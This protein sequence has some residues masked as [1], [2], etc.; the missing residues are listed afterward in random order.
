MDRNP[1]GPTLVVLF[2]LF[3]MVGNG[4]EASLFAKI[5]KLAGGVG[6]I[7]KISPSPSPNSG[8]DSGPSRV[9][10]VNDPAAPAPGPAAYGLTTERCTSSMKTCHYKNQI[11]MT[12]CLVSSSNAHM[13]LFLLVQNDEEGSLEVNVTSNGA[14]KEIKVPEHQIKEVNVSG[15]GS[16]PVVLNAGNGTCVILLEL[17]GHDNGFFKNLS[18]YADYATPLN[19]AY[20][21]FFTVFIIGGVCTCCMLGK[22]GR[23]AGGVPY[24][25]LEMGHPDSP[26]GDGDVETAE[27]W[28]QGWDDDWDEIKAVKSPR[29]RRNGNVSTNGLSSRSSDKDGWENNWDD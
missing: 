20:F 12:A 5:R 25:E 15:G 6:P 10:K 11:N 8:V 27:R 7:N 13:E 19:G 26:S 17:P 29:A 23:H 9:H 14:S 22:R 2:L 21:L 16:S 18:N 3:F 4:C 24:R 1:V 28:D